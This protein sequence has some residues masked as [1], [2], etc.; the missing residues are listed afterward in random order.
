MLIPLSLTLQATKT[1]G[2]AAMSG[3]DIGQVMEKLMYES[4]DREVAVGL[5]SIK[6]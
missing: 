4:V 1:N 5:Y 2:K 6:L 3:D